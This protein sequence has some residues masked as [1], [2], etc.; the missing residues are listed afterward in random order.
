MDGGEEVVVTF[1]VAGGDGAEVLQFVEEPL[2]PVALAV[3]N[4]VEGRK[5]D[6]GRHQPDVGHCPAFGE[7]FAQ[8]V[9]VIG[10]V[11]EQGLAA[12]TVSYISAAE[13]PSCA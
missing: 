7:A 8:A 4:G 9:A 5:P 6:P 13:R 12:R 3:E 11:G 1:V 10:A 2:D